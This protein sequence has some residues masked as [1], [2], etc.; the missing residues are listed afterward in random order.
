MISRYDLE[1]YGRTVWIKQ[2]NASG[3][4]YN[5]ATKEYDEDRLRSAIKVPTLILRY[6]GQV[7]K[8]LNPMYSDYLSTRIRCYLVQKAKRALALGLPQEKVRGE[9]YLRLSKEAPRDVDECKKWLTQKLI[10][11]AQSA[12]WEDHIFNIACQDLMNVLDDVP[13]ITSPKHIETGESALGYSTGIVLPP[14]TIKEP[15]GVLVS[16]SVTYKG[17][18][19]RWIRDSRGNTV[20]SRMSKHFLAYCDK[21]KECPLRNKYNFCMG[22]KCR[23]SVS[24]TISVRGKRNND[25]L[26]R[27]QVSVLK[28]LANDPFGDPQLQRGLVLPFGEYAFAIHTYDEMKTALSD[29]YYKASTVR[30]GDMVVACARKDFFQS[31]CAGTWIAMDVSKAS[32]VP[33]KAEVGGLIYNKLTKVFVSPT[34]EHPWKMSFLQALFFSSVMNLYERVLTKEELKALLPYHIYGPLA[35]RAIRSGG[36]GNLK[37]PVSVLVQTNSPWNGVR[38]NV[39]GIRW[40]N[41]TRDGNWV[42]QGEVSVEVFVRDV[43]PEIVDKAVRNYV[44]IGLSRFTFLGIPLDEKDLRWLRECAKAY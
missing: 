5:W 14:E 36:L 15:R 24:A 13:K 29:S 27:S 19:G 44:K 28:G 42:G 38:H 41:N 33:V 35:I 17:D 10:E 6:D 23:I 39:E 43:Y 34:G 3:L 30:I 9:S 18:L 22:Y 20:G 25:K 40:Q 37:E 21:I 4:V 16:Y 7:Y 11:T 32:F 8:V 12:D 31:R 26:A 2:F 1:T